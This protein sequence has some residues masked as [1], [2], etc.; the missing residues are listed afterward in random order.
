[1][2]YYDGFDNLLDD[3]RIDVNRY[4]SF[5]REVHRLAF[6]LGYDLMH[7]RLIN[8]DDPA[9]DTVYEKC[10]KLAEQ[11]MESEEYKDLNYSEYEA[12]ENWLHKVNKP[13]FVNQLDTMAIVDIQS[14]LMALGCYSNSE[15]NE[16]MNEKIV[17]LI[18]AIDEE[19]RARFGD[20][21]SW[22]GDGEQ[23]DNLYN[24]FY[25]AQLQRRKEFGYE[26]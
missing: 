9:C 6:I 11:F 21:I 26:L 20:S 24:A 18:P 10:L 2:M 17:D 14:R 12:F 23:F 13:V 19:E 8:S 7:D 1:M 22:V 15:I 16:M 3:I 25:E 5:M 4:D